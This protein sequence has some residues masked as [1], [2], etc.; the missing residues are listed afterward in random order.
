[1]PAIKNIEVYLFLIKQM[2]D[3]YIVEIDNFAKV[4]KQNKLKTF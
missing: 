2:K 4:K 1:M 3:N